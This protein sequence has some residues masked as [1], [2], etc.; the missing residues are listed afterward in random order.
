MRSAARACVVLVVLA[1]I[2]AH[3]RALGHGFVY[4]DH[5][6]I[7]HN[8][9]LQPPIDVVAYFRD[10]GT[11]SAAAGNAGGGV[12]GDVGRR[13]SNSHAGA[14]AGSAADEASHS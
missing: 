1:A 5:R 14:L 13:R 10:P 6:F 11:A 2:F 9:A 7:E 12:G 4:D 3:A 8:R